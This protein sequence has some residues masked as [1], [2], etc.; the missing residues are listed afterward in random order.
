MN[1]H[2]NER[3]DLRMALLPHQ[4]ALVETFFEPTSNRVLLLRGEVGLGKSVALV[5]LAGRLLRERPTSR[6]LLLVPAALR[7]MFMEM[8][9]DAC[10]PSLPV[11]RYVFRELLDAKTEGDLWPRGT[12][13]VLSR[14]F[15]KQPDILDTL[16]EVHWDLLVVDEAHSFSG[17]QGKKAL[18]RIAPSAERVLIA[19]ATDLDLPA[20]FPMHATQVIEWRRDQVVDHNG[21]ALTAVPAPVLHEAPFILS[22]P[23]LHLIETVADLC[24]TIESCAR[25]GKLTG[26]ILLRSL[27]SSPAALEN[28]LSR[29]MARSDA[30]DGSQAPQESQEEDLETDTIPEPMPR[31]A[32][33][34]VIGVAKPALEESAAIEADS[35]LEAFDRILRDLDARQAPRR[36]CVFTDHVTTL[37]YLSAEIEGLGLS[38]RLF[39]G[40]MTP[41][42]RQDSLTSFSEGHG[43]LVGTSAVMTEGV[44]IDQVT[45][46]V[47]YDVPRSLLLIQQLLGRFDRF[48]RQNPLNVHVLVP[49][50]TADGLSASP[51]SVLRDVL[52]E[53]ANPQRSR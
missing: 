23:E 45:D 5:A 14:D 30:F 25:Q 6:V 17:T 4:K 22:Q 18:I 16:A 11:D 48:G 53:R 26:Q 32:A 42:E 40:G 36:I 13:I 35:K 21:I 34:S 8:F 44:S 51:I 19:T 37:Y 38:C 20:L 10:T 24:R 52:D 2:G 41:N 28:T 49:S 46:L 33:D 3:K 15:A 47:L 27:Q 9:H 50:N 1:Q 31:E 43:I 7:S 39:H 29:L 12:V